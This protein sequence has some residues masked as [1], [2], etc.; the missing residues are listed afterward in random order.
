M[1]DRFKN[2]E[3]IIAL[4]DDYKKE[5][6]DLLN[7]AAEDDVLADHLRE[8]KEAWRI[9]RIR[10]EAMSKRSRAGW[11][12]ARIEKLGDALSTIQTPELPECQTDGSIPK[13]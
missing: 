3:E 2:K 7:D 5:R 11:R 10:G 9:E 6:D 4:I 8:T 13:S 12:Q 1:S